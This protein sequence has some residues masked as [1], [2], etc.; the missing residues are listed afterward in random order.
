VR[1]RRTVAWGTIDQGLSSLTNLGLTLFGARLIGPAGLGIVSVGFSAYVLALVLQ[2]TLLSQPVVLESTTS[3]AAQRE[4]ST[5][6]GITG[7]LVVGV[8]ASAVLVGV[9]LVAPDSVIGRGALV[10]APWMPVALLQDYWRSVLFRDRRGGAAAVNDLAWLVVMAL[11]LPLAFVARTDVALVAC[12][13]L[14]AT[15]AAVLGFVQT[16][17]R[18]RGLRSSW[19]WWRRGDGW[20]VGRW[21]TAEGLAYSGLSQAVTWVLAVLLGPAALGGLRAARTVFAPLTLLGPAVV[22]PGL[23]AMVTALDTSLRRARALALRLGGILVGMTLPYLA[24]VAI[25]GGDRILG[26]LFG[27]SFE[28]FGDLA[29]PIA[30]QQT[31]M[32]AGTGLYLLLKAA[33]R[34]QALLTFRLIEAAATLALVVLA[35][36]WWE[37]GLLGAAWAITVGAAFGLAWK[38]RYVYRVLGREDHAPGSDDASDVPVGPIPAVADG[39]DGP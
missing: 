19:S 11:A 10:F 18:P 14:G 16:G 12:W 23:P 25:V 38:V 34:G 21:F 28:R 29:L 17:A 33:R 6:V 35:T 3:D 37:W 15:A 20:L 13:G 36:W 8:L 24:L 5:R 9:Y 26:W 1:L 4:T 30:A 22:L 39:A 2:R 27:E 32:A 31:L 7:T